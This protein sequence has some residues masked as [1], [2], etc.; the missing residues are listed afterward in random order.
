MTRSM[1]ATFFWIAAAALLIFEGFVWVRFGKWPGY[2]IIDAVSYLGT[3][4]M[5]RW[6]R[7]PTS[8]AEL[9]KVLAACPLPAALALVA[10]G[11]SWG[12]WRR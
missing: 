8:W 7:A 1:L 9:H 11:L 10:M 5:T 4:A 2:D 3:P 12:A 6:A